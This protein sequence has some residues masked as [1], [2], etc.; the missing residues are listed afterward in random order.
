MRR[1]KVALIF[2]FCAVLLAGGAV[3]PWLVAYFQDLADMDQVRYGDIDVIQLNFEQERQV[4]T[5]LGKLNLLQSAEMLEV[6]DAEAQMDRGELYATIQKVLLPYC[7]VGLISSEW[8][9]DLECTAILAYDPEDAGRY[10]ILWNVYFMNS[11]PHRGLT[12]YIDDE[13]GKILF[14]DYF[15]EEFCYEMEKNGLDYILCLELFY[16]IYFDSLELEMPEM[17]PVEEVNVPEAG[18]AAVESHWGDVLY[19]EFSVRFNIN[20]VGFNTTYG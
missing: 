14:I 16:K 10:M 7:D 5:I 13:T 18:S 1:I 17:E 9:S 4:L 6:S 12:M 15:S 11:D 8:D 3:F 2:L 19:G 20:S